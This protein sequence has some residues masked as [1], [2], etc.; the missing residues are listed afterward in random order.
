MK[1]LKPKELRQR[2]INVLSTILLAIF[3]IVGTVF[4]WMYAYGYRFSLEGTTFEKTGVL[5]IESNPTWANIFLDGENKGQTSK[6]IGSIK[7]GSYQVR[8]EKENYQTW[9]KTLPIRAELSTPTNAFLFLSNATKTNSQSITGNV[10]GIVLSQN[11]DHYFVE[12]SNT[13]ETVA[14][15]PSLIATPTTQK[16]FNVYDYKINRNF[17][18]FGDNPTLVFSLTIPATDLMTVTP[19]ENGEFLLITEK[20]DAKATDRKLYLV[21][22]NTTQAIPEEVNLKSYSQYSIDWA[23]DSKHLILESS[24]EILSYDVNSKAIVV[25]L[26]KDATENNSTSDIKWKTDKSGNFYYVDLVK[27]TIE[28]FQIRQK[29]LNGTNDKIVLDEIYWQKEKA[30]LEINSSELVQPFTNSPQSTRFVGKLINFY[31]NTEQKGIVIETEYA[32]YWY[33]TKLQKYFVVDPNNCTFQSYSIDNTKFAFIDNSTKALRIF[34]FEVKDIDH[35]SKI[36][37]KTILANTADITIDS[38]KWTQN[39]LYL[40]YT[41]GKDIYVVDFDGE[42]IFKLLA[43]TAQEIQNDYIIDYQ[44]Q[45]LFMP[46]V[47]GYTGKIEKYQIH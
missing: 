26:R 40:S 33:D 2:I 12:T 31:P 38:L 45:N 41:Q 13:I 9:Q 11:N 3:I 37:S 22:T 46:S 36:G 17:W 34:T 20:T 15:T 27:D 28:Y 39:S 8:V 7:E 29:Q 18:D 43:A 44:V 19:S 10:K 21:K 1:K 35:V 32:I 5:S 4:V 30:F 42:N 14:T 16:T 23:L 24:T 47:E 25:L 6:T